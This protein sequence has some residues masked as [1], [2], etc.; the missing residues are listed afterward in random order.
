VAKPS[1]LLVDGDAKSLRVL[2]VSLKKAGFIVTTAENGADALTK[3]ETAQPDLILSDTRMP[4]MDGFEF[5]RKLKQN[6]EWG[7]IPFIF[8]TGQKSIEDK[9]KGLELG[10]ED[11]LTKPIY[12]KEIITRVKILLQKRAR[13][14]IQAAPEGKKESRTKF[15]GHLADMAV[16]DLIQTID[17]SRKSGVIHIRSDEGKSGAIY[18]R[19][20]K[21]VDAELGRL[22]G[23]AAVYRMLLWN[24][25]EFEVEFKNIRRRDA[26]D[27]SPQALLMEGMRRMDEW[28]RMLEQLPPLDTVFEVDYHELAERLSEI[29]DEVNGILRLFD[30]RRDLM[31]IVDDADFSDLETLNLIGKLY[32]EGLIYDSRAA[33][34]G[35]PGEQ[36]PSQEV[37]SWLADELTSPRT[38]VTDPGAGPPLETLGAAAP[39]EV[40]GDEEGER[41][42]AGEPPRRATLKQIAPAAPPAAVAPADVS[43]P[44]APPPAAP[45]P[46]AAAGQTP[47][48]EASPAPSAAPS[49][50][51]TG[52]AG[53][54][55]LAAEIAN[56]WP[57]A[58][59]LTPAPTSRPTLRL[60]LEPSPPAA[61][62]AVAAAAAVAAAPTAAVPALTPPAAATGAAPT[63][64]TPAA[65]GPATAALSTL[66]PEPTPLLPEAPA[67]TLAPP[68]PAAA[69]PPAAPDT[70][71]PAPPIA[72]EMLG[73]A[74][75]RALA[76]AEKEP[77]AVTADAT[78]ASA[79]ANG[80]AVPEILPPLQPLDTSA[81]TPPFRAPEPPRGAPV[82][83]DSRD[84]RSVSGVF[85]ITPAPPPRMPAEPPVVAPEAITAEDSLE[86]KRAVA[87]SRRFLTLGLLAAAA[88]VGVGGYLLWVSGKA[89]VD[90]PKVIV[91][92]ARD[93]APGSQPLALGATG[94]AGA[95]ALVALALDGA[96]AG[97]AADAGA[98]TAAGAVAA[99]AGAPSAARPDAA[100]AKVAAATD[101]GA[102]RPPVAAAGDGG[103]AAEDVAAL[104]RDAAAL[105]KK[106]KRAAAIAMYEKAA[107]VDPAA[108]AAPLALANLYLD[109]GN[110]KKAAEWAQKAIAA[111]AQ[112][113]DAYMV[114][115]TANLDLGR[116]ADAR[117]AFRKYLEL[118]PKGRHAADV[119]ALLRQ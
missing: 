45:P 36:V 99:A 84:S 2:E 112:G 81:L 85:S 111:N 67:V 89:T 23:E 65:P 49:A 91:A 66:L 113:A 24:D 60:G 109:S 37:E 19:T 22:Q 95:G 47:A 5:C 52:A 35:S 80:D 114:L 92:L 90:T 58:S 83:S 87:P 78:P 44:A 110:N 64:P 50:S 117:A 9:I 56:A 11:Y 72:A 27:L 59:S 18:F 103:A 54:E 15:S 82:E 28:G 100:A 16:V 98:P 42:P 17:I 26:I 13:D 106:G 79:A 57:D 68:E 104:V 34:A 14:Q 8:L 102:A 116:N 77:A 88:M 69:P 33:S 105:R 115:G 25:G 73:P 12:I 29:P 97:T 53:L 118:A 55:A 76:A 101:A 32:F 46:A 41:A 63:A 71:T 7:P 75:E 21:L 40:G 43:P 48:P 119:R 96:A 108:D 10:V 62:P 70:A 51:A 107:A 86:F 30:G 31:G 6:P 38:G 94:D 93:A 4:E 20:G 1:L 39:V 74:L 3:V 61:A